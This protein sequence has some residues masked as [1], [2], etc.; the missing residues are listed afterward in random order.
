MRI[1]FDWSALGR[2]RWY[3]YLL[4]ILL[5]GLV[6]VLAGVL[7]DRFGASV[8][9]LFL[10]FPAIFPASA[11]LVQKHEE[12]KK[13]QAGI[14]RTS[15]GRQ[16]A[17]LDAAG[18]VLGALSLVAFAGVVYRWLPSW[19]APAA[20]AAACVLWLVLAGSLWWLRKRHYPPARQP[21]QPLRR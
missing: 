1:T 21:V 12:K 7:A 18:A 6:C 8:G 15:R 10:A 17:G 5:G 14:A 20:I 16:A 3:E 19:P 2:T 4:R 11:T 9:G 13:R